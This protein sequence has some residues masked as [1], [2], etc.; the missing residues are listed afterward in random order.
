MKFFNLFR[1][2]PKYIVCLDLSEL[3]DGMNIDDW[4]SHYKKDGVIFL[5]SF[6]NAD[7][8]KYPLSSHIIKV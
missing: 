2:K 7:G 1:R 4:M 5:K 8:T 3:P 6:F